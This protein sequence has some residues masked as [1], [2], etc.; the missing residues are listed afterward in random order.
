M[1]NTNIHRI[2]I[3]REKYERIRHKKNNL[4]LKLFQ[5]KFLINT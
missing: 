3:I 2:G 5:L 1:G 4:F